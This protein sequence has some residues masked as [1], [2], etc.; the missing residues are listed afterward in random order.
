MA[1]GAVLAFL[2]FALALT[3]V[4]PSKQNV[5]HQNVFGDRWGGSLRCPQ[6]YPQMC[7]KIIPLQST[8]KRC[9]LNEHYFGIN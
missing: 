4:R 8:A 7:P 1:R 2:T 5:V 3:R 6:V 9:H